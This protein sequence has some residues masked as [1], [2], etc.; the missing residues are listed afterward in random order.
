MTRESRDSERA[1][2]LVLMGLLDTQLNQEGEP[3]LER[4]PIFFEEAIALKDTH[5]L[6]RLITTYEQRDQLDSIFRYI[7]DAAK[8]GH[9]TCV[10]QYLNH[11]EN[12]DE[13]AKETWADIIK[14]AAKSEFELNQEYKAEGYQNVQVEI[15]DLLY[16]KGVSLKREDISKALL[17]KITSS[18]QADNQLVNITLNHAVDNLDFKF[19]LRAAKYKNWKLVARFLQENKVRNLAFVFG[20]EEN[21]YME[22]LAKIISEPGRCQQREEILSLLFELADAHQIAN[23]RAVR[24]MVTP[25]KLYPS[26]EMLGPNDKFYYLKHNHPEKQVV[27]RNPLYSEPF[28]SEVSDIIEKKGYASYGNDLNLLNHNT[29]RTISYNLKAN[30]FIL[31]IVEHNS[32]SL[33]ALLKSGAGENGFSLLELKH[34]V[35]WNHKHNGQHN[36]KLIEHFSFLQKHLEIQ[37][38]LFDSFKRELFEIFKVARE[39]NN[40]E[41]ALYTLQTISNKHDS[42]PESKENDTMDQGQMEQFVAAML[43][44]NEP[45]IE[46]YEQLL[47]LFRQFKKLLLNTFDQTLDLDISNTLLIMSQNV[48]KMSPPIMSPEQLYDWQGKIRTNCMGLIKQTIDELTQ[49]A[50]SKKQGIENILSYLEDAKQK[51]IINAHRSKPNPYNWFKSTSSVQQINGMIKRYQKEHTLELELELENQT[52]QAEDSAVASCS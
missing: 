13:N 2:R 5:S 44:R 40:K 42:D 36:K 12:I 52:S 18:N 17:E 37:P 27:S 4:L 22:I 46:N 11:I 39:A 29:A 49:Q 25:I 24:T 34:L 3:D 6:K 51:P 47:F 38:K 9:W 26:M 16:A 32:E 19:I 31:A 33:S 7:Q 21:D 14:L 23:K 48:R 1:R 20:V 50:T 28:S 41:I 10:L 43:I 30:A 45:D 8:K 35:I 15:I